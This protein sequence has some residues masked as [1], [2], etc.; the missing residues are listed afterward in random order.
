[1]MAPKG[2]DPLGADGVRVWQDGV[3]TIA[4]S[5]Y[6]VRYVVARAL[7]CLTPCFGFCAV[8]VGGSPTVHLPL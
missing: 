4:E 2:R 8:L 1:M 5:A 7:N 6:T 3:V